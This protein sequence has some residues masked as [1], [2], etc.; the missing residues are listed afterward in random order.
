MS[1]DDCARLVAAGDPDRFAAV[2][3]A[4]PSA[5]ASLLPLYAFNLEVARAPW[6][7]AEPLIA[8]MRLQWWADIAEEIGQGGTRAHE[9][10]APLATLVQEAG[11]PVALLTDIVEARRAD[12]YP[13]GPTAEEF[14][15]YIDRT[16]GHLMWLAAL[17]LGAEAGLEPKV[18]AHAHAQGVAALLQATAELRARG[19]IPL[20]SECD[21]P[22]LARTA[23]KRQARAGRVPRRI[24]P[25]VLPAWQ[26]AA[27]LRL[28]EKEPQ[29]IEEGRLA[30]PEFRKRG[31]LLL[32]AFLG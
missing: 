13:E 32:R 19:R 28:A 2:M 12:I 7:S 26:A 29:R 25:A 20:P 3:A 17:S 14:D 21:I 9:V 22:A 1:L 5:R 10:V 23:R 8:E 4:P 15:R 31:A 30:L 16:A 6:A 11:L 27:L 18:R 24:A